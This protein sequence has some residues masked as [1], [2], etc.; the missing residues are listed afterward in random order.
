MAGN[1]VIGAYDDIYY[2]VNGYSNVIGGVTIGIATPTNKLEDSD[3]SL[4]RVAKMRAW[5]K[6]PITSV[7]ATVE[8]AITALLGHCEVPKMTDAARIEY[9]IAVY[10]QR[11]EVRAAWR[12]VAPLPEALMERL[13]AYME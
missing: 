4:M 7:Y 3:T 10:L 12:R 9:A 13:F 6:N 5:V 11:D 2:N 8:D 1:V